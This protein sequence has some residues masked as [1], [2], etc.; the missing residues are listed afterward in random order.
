MDTRN[1]VLFP[2]KPHSLTMRINKY[3][4]L[5]LLSSIW[6]ISIG[7]R[8]MMVPTEA[9]VNTG[10]S[11]FFLWEALIVFGLILFVTALHMFQKGSFQMK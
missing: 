6:M 3:R 2:S 7:F 9:I 5:L 1:G 4:M 11:Q 8:V 10:F